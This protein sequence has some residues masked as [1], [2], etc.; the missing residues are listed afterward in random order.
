M[1]P[2]S[3][4]LEPPI[5]PA[6]FNPERQIV[7]AMPALKTRSARRRGVVKIGDRVKFRV[8]AKVGKRSNMEPRP[9][10]RVVDVYHDPDVRN[11]HRADVRFGNELERQRVINTEE[12]EVLPDEEIAEDKG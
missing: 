10:G 3:Q 5:N 2:P 12:L 9:T 7:F 8:G 11:G 1:A 6:R 4:E